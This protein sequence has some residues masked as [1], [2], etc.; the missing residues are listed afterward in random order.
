MEQKGIPHHPVRVFFSLVM[1]QM[2]SVIFAAP[3]YAM[4]LSLTGII[5][6]SVGRN[7]IGESLI[8][9][10]FFPV[11]IFF[12]F[13]YGFPAFIVGYIVSLWLLSAAELRPWV[14]VFMLGSIGLIW[15]LMPFY[16]LPDLTFE[17][18]FNFFTI[19]CFLTASGCGYFM[20]QYALQLAGVESQED[21]SRPKKPPVD[22]RFHMRIFFSL[23]LAYG[24]SA[25][26]LVPPL[27]SFL[28]A[29][30]DSHRGFIQSLLEIYE[31]MIF[32]LPGLTLWAFVPSLPVIGL[33]HLL[34]IR[35]LSYKEQGAWA[36]ILPILR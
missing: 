6:G 27:F 29:S 32:K 25:L 10:A 15:G 8:V 12:S 24:F 7:I 17:K 5:T 33:A 22:I 1:Y 26:I 4:L 34:T 9:L 21:L 23:L 20:S 16:Y 14:W 18:I 36:W 11:S 13:F 2:V 28:R 31:S 3:V 35:L 19:M 30:L